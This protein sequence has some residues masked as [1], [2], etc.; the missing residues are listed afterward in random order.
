MPHVRVTIASNVKQSQRAPLLIPASRPSE[1]VHP[2]SARS[3]VLK[4]ATSKLRIKKPSR[5]YIAG[6]GQELLSA[7]DWDH[8]VQNDAVLLVSAGEEYVGT[9]AAAKKE[10]DGF[11][12][13][14]ADV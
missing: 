14:K 4:A 1:L 6:T 10:Y 3:L 12:Y 5:V 11:H 9:K 13:L 8:S 7:Y 2:S